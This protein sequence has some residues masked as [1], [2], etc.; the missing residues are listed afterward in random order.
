MEKL[1]PRRVDF[2]SRYLA[3]LTVACLFLAGLAYVTYNV[4]EVWTAGKQ[5]LAREVWSDWG[6]LP[7]LALWSLDQHDDVEFLSYSLV[8]SNRDGAK[9][10][11]RQPNFTLH[12]E[13]PNSQSQGKRRLFFNSSEDFIESDVEFKVLY[14][15][16]FNASAMGQSQDVFQDMTLKVYEPDGDKR[17]GG[18][19]AALSSTDVPCF[20]TTESVEPTSSRSRLSLMW[21]LRLRQ[22]RYESETG[23]TIRYVSDDTRPFH[24]INATLPTEPVHARAAQDQAPSQF[25]GPTTRFVHWAIYVPH[26]RTVKVTKEVTRLNQTIQ[27]AGNFG[28][29]L[30]IVGI[31]YGYCFPRKFERTNTAATATIRV[32]RFF[33]KREGPNE[34]ADVEQERYLEWR[35]GESL[36]Q[37]SAGEVGSEGVE[38]TEPSNG[39]AKC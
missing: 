36:L 39:A 27:Q 32:F 38:L 1:D 16:S 33:K 34:L 4:H 3:L 20:T 5:K 25:C 26:P 31:L 10:P 35:L 6:R 7:T 12:D 18:T 22:E 23:E 9:V 17:Y 29:V 24:V 11:Q 14:R 8:F 37:A 15:Q 28:G 21:M 2:Q 30:T 19:L 13:Q